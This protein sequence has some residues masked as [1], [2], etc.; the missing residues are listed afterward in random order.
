QKVADTLV[1]LCE[2]AD[3]RAAVTPATGGGATGCRRAVMGALASQISEVVAGLT[4][5][6]AASPKLRFADIATRLMSSSDSAFAAAVDTGALSLVTDLTEDASDVLLQ[7]NALDLLDRVASTAAGA[8]HLVANG[9]L[10]RL[11]V[12]A[13][14]GDS[15]DAPD[16]L[17]GA[18]AL[19][20]LAKVL[21]QAGDA[22]LDAWKERSPSSLGGFLRACTV[23]VQGQDE[24]G[25]IST[26]PGRSG[27][28]IR[29]G[30]RVRRGPAG[31][32]LPGARFGRRARCLVDAVGT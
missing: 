14:G 4:S 7:L 10:D 6:Q 25:K 13:G 5:R 19:R 9:H 18:S 24:A 16:P 1:A 3:G 8:R 22:G 15:P 23:H 32:A 21:A 28:G 17:L 29:G 20:T 12:A 30:S 31:D 27:G 2:E 11:L 26:A